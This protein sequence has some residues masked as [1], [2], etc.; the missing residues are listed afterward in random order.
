MARAADRFRFPVRH[1]Y[2]AAVRGFAAEPSPAVREALAADP[3][4]ERLAADAR[5]GAS[6]QV[7]PSGV[8]RIHGDVSA[9]VP[10]GAAQQPAINVNVAVLDSGID[11]GHPDLN[12]AGGV[13][14]VGGRRFDDRYGH[15]THIGGIIGALNN[16]IG[17][18]GVAAGARLWGV[19]VLDDEGDGTVSDLLCG[20]DWVTATRLDQDRSNDIAVANLSVGG[21]GGDDGHCGDVDGD[22]LHK[23]ICRSVAAGTTYVAAAGNDHVDASATIP[24]AYAEVITVSALADSDGRAGGLGG[25]PS[26]RSNEQDGR[27]YYF[28]SDPEFDNLVEKDEFLEYVE[29]PWGARSGTLRSEIDRIQAHGKVALLD[30]ETDGALRV[31]ETI[32]G[33]VTIFVDAPTFEELERRLRE[34]ATESSGEIQVRLALARRQQEQKDRFDYVIVNDDVNRAADELTAIVQRQLQA[35]GTMSRP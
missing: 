22:V 6:G 15:G 26:C 11:P 14:C 8:R 13:N 31:Q 17:V 7:V 12:V 19:K 2:H 35:A 32:L 27:E 21:R 20:V 9:G 33:A 23:A 28:L 1:V 30:L 34:R 29:L 3:G 18:V 16:T 10:P 5:L 4:V 24:A 25:P